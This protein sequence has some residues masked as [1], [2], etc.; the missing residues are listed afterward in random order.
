MAK[1]YCVAN[2]KG[3]VGKTTTAV[4]LAA[5]LS[6][7]GFKVLL[8]D[9]D[10]QGNATTASGI[11]KIELCRSVYDVMLGR[12]TLKEVITHS[13]SGYD[14][15]GSNR[16]LA[17]A[18][19]ELLSAPEKEQALK[20]ALESCSADYDIVLID[21]PPA[22]SILTVNAFVASAGLIIPM[23]CEYFSLEGVSDLLLTIKAVRE[24]INS[25]LVIAG[26]L[27]VKFD[28]RITLQRQVSDQLAGFFK[29]AVYTTVIP[30]NVR[31]A[32][33]PSH[34]ESVLS[35]D[36]ASKGS[37]AYKALGKEFVKKEKLKPAK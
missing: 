7:L 9:L 2:Q 11:N 21:C 1:I 10:P 23:T 3:G 13:N 29:D 4:N 6:E 37:Q 34:G 16:R 5:A 19:E 12:I 15:A 20:K 8:I 36:A 33:A 17:A 31:L 18:E 35:Y 14:I 24:K 25:H 26:L 27:R 32:E 28:P 30:T 22:L